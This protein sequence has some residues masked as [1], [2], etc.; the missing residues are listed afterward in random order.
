MTPRAPTPLDPVTAAVLD[1]LRPYLGAVGAVAM[2][3]STAEVAVPVVRCLRRRSGVPVGPGLVNL[4]SGIVA[5][6][7]AHHVRRRPGE[8]Q[9]WQRRRIPRWAWLAGLVHLTLSP[10][11]A[12]WG[13]RGV[14]RPGRSPLWAGLVSPVG[15][16]RIALG[17]VAYT[18]VCRAR[19]AGTRP[20]AGG[21]LS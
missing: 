8:W 19:A 13:D 14:I 7:V 6:G 20:G 1:D 11:V 21:A 16:L 12:A 15:L 5:L 3:G 10:A 18:R 2:L 4:A 17:L 9:R